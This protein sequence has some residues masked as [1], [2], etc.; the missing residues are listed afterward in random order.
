MTLEVCQK[1]ENVLKVFPCNTFICWLSIRI[2]LKI[3][4][5]SIRLC[6]TIDCETLKRYIL[7]LTVTTQ[8]F[9]VEIFF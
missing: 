5:L 3:D 2:C 1:R 6:L 9:I 4:W 8:K 7:V